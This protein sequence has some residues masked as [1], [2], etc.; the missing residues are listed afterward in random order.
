[1][2]SDDSLSRPLKRKQTVE[3]LKGPAPLRVNPIA[4][5]VNGAGK[6]EI[7]PRNLVRGDEADLLHLRAY[8]R[9]AAD[10]TCAIDHD[11]NGL[12]RVGVDAVYAVQYDLNV[13]LFTRLADC[14]CVHR[15]AP[16]YKT[17]GEGP[18]AEGG[19]DA[20]TDQEQSAINDW[21][22]RRNQLGVE[23]EDEVTPAAHHLLLLIRRDRLTGKGAAA[24]RAV[25]K[26]FWA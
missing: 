5:G 6:R 16:L 18:L 7:I 8:R 14:R 17:A 1:M 26:R 21:E 23:V 13:H 20:A 10:E 3:C 15:F 9:A 19:L 22:R 11:R 25:T 24:N 2:G 12:I 4:Q